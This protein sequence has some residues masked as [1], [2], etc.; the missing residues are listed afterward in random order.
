MSGG[1]AVAFRSLVD[2]GINHGDLDVVDELVAED[3]VEH[4]YG[5]PGHGRDVVR[6]IFS[7]TRKMIPDVVL[8]VEDLSEQDD[9]VW[10]RM[11]ARGTHMTG[12]RIEIDVIDIARFDNGQMVEHWGVPDRFALLDQLGLLPQPPT[13]QNS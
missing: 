5:A 11:R 10:F 8:T 7:D 2:R 4:Q 12:T 6:A 1:N 9:K 3:L 13:P